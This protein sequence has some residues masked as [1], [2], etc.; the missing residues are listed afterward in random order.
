MP[1]LSSQAELAKILQGSIGLYKLPFFYDPARAVINAGWRPPVRVITDPAELDALPDGTVILDDNEEF[2]RLNPY[3]VDGVRTWYPAWLS[4]NAL[5]ED[6]GQVPALPVTVVH[7][8][9][10]GDNR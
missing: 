5:A 4:G 2:H 6:F 1:D 7:T 3:G 8:P 10:N 9:E